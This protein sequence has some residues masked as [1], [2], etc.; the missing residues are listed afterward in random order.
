VEQ[1]VT[2]ETSQKAMTIEDME[3][4]MQW[5]ESLVL[6]GVADDKFGVLLSWQSL[7]R[8]FMTSGFTL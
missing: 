2:L 7:M 5:S 4:L 6:H 3:K 8:A 1:K